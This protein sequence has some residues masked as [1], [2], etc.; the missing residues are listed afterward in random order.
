MNNLEKMNR[1]ETMAYI[2]EHFSYGEETLRLID[3]I[4]DYVAMQ[5]LD[6]KEQFSL[7][8]RLLDNTIGLSNDELKR[9]CL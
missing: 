9:I 7:L 1:H 2:Q 3:N 4:L 6:E 5:E 8:Q